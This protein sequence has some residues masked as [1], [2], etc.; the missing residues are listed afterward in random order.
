M[1]GFEEKT[2]AG[3]PADTFW[4]V[5]W[6]KK[7]LFYNVRLTKEADIAPIRVSVFRAARTF[8]ECWEPVGIDYRQSADILEVPDGKTLR[9]TITE[10]AEKLIRQAIHA[11]FPSEISIMHGYGWDK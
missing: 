9:K 2:V 6:G 11:E 10:T 1:Q 3:L 4:P 5:S 7:G 8:C